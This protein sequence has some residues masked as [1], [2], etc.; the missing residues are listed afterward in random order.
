MK[1]LSIIPSARKKKGRGKIKTN[2]AY[3]WVIRYAVQSFQYFI[4]KLIFPFRNFGRIQ[5]DSG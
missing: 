5:L 4:T 3:N 1:A 2:I